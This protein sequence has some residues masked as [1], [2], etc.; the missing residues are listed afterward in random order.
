M[1][2]VFLTL[3]SRGDVQPYAALAK[4]LIKTGMSQ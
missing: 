2:V 3:G 4:E 1:R